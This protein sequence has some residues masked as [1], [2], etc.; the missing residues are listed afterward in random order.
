MLTK[1]ELHE[2]YKYTM[3]LSAWSF[4]SYRG[5]GLKPIYTCDGPCGLRIEEADHKIA[6][7]LN[8]PS[9]SALA[10]SFNKELIRLNGEIIGR[11]ANAKKRD[12]LLAPGLNIKRSA[13]C[14]RNFEYFSEDP[15]LNGVCGT[16]YVKGVQSQNVG[17][18]IKHLCCNS[19]EFARYL[20]SAEV[21]Q[22]ALNEIYLEPFRRVIK[23]TNPI[24]IMTSYNKVNGVYNFDNKDFLE[25]KIVKQFGFDG[26]FVSDWLSVSE[27]GSA[28]HGGL[29]LEMPKKVIKDKY[30]DRELKKGVF[31]EEE[32]I[33]NDEHLENCLSKLRALPKEAVF[34]LEKDHKDAEEIANETSVLVKNSNKVLPLRKKDKVLVVGDIDKMR[35]NGGGSASVNAYKAESIEACFAETWLDVRFLKTYDFDLDDLGQYSDVNKI[36]FFFQQEWDQEGNDRYHYLCPLKQEI[37]FDKIKQL[38]KSIVSVIVTGSSFSIKDFYKESKAVLI[39]Y[40]AGECQNKSL[41]N[42]LV[43]KVNPSGHLAETWMGSLDQNPM[44]KRDVLKRPFYYSYYDEDIYVG[45]RYFD[46]HKRGFVLPFG[47]GLSYSKFAYSNPT[48]TDCGDTI[49]FR[50]DVENKS[51]IDGKETL[52]VFSALPNSNV[53]RPCKEL[54]GFDKELVTAKTTK[55]FVISVNKADLVT[56]RKSKDAMQVEEGTYHFYLAKNAN[57]VLG[58]FDLFV[59]GEQFEKQEKPVKLKRKKVAK[60][61]TLDTD[62][63]SFFQTSVCQEIA[64]QK[65]QP[66]D[67]EFAE[68]WQSGCLRW[69]SEKYF[70]GIS[71]DEIHSKIIPELKRRKEKPL[72]IN[73]MSDVRKKKLIVEPFHRE[74][75]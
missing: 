51:N 53:Y 28:I 3:G 2:R 45:Y 67:V 57:E 14:G 40:F 18:S 69:M 19:Q 59:N 27:K 73:Y 47:Y 71:H 34:D 48:M 8:L 38:G 42:T 20:V 62:M 50:I 11:E 9:P 1:K 56:Y 30:V 70:W 10:T 72:G 61:W 15:Y 58:E 55:T 64:K 24:S 13:L 43:G 66:L 65:N 37:A 36:V 16:E 74:R 22:R 52:F 25:N 44:Y 4:N 75:K 35:F 54:K 29:H 12:I 68:R 46:L 49:E 23:E 60:T 32:L 33:Q 6:V 26:F 63:L 5:R 41:V 17:V 21:S 7:S 39:Q 31:T